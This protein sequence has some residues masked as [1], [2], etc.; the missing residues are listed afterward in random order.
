MFTGIIQAIGR[1]QR[2]SERHLLITAASAPFLKD[3]AI[4]DSIAVDGVCL[5]VEA[6]DRTSFKVSVSPETLE[7]TTLGEKADQG[8]AVNLE[9]A[10]R[11]GDKLGGHFVTGHVDGVGHLRA[12]APM[13]ESW[14]LTVAAPPSVATYIIRKGSIAINGISLTVA[15]CNDEGD[16]FSV[17]VIPHSYSHTTLQYLKVGDAVNLEADLLGKYTQKFLGRSPSTAPADSAITIEFLQT[18]GYAN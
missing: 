10:L 12:I 18:H 1:L 9:P 7:R 3:I 17:A 4:G 11:V 14:E 16:E 15:T 8:A 2:Q 6:F 5:T 13:G